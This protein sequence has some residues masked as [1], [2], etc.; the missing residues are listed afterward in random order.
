MY[1]KNRSRKISD[2]ELDSYFLDGFQSAEGPLMFFDTLTKQRN[3]CTG[4]I[5]LET[6]GD[7]FF[8]IQTW[9]QLSMQSFYERSQHWMRIISETGGSYQNLAKSLF[10]HFLP[11]EE[12]PEN[13]ELKISN[14]ESKLLQWKE[15]QEKA[16]QAYRIHPELEEQISQCPWY[17]LFC[18]PRLKSSEWQIV[19]PIT[20]LL[21]NFP[22]H[23]LEDLV[24]QM[25][26]GPDIDNFLQ[27]ENDLSE[28]MQN[29]DDLD[30]NELLDRLPSFDNDWVGSP[31]FVMPKLT[32]GDRP[33]FCDFI[34]NSWYSISLI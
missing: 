19:S 32:T 10:T 15:D 7:Y 13:I 16:I 33:S 2:K 27:A 17:N 23:P 5:T 25:A 34:D 30:I 28:Y 21:D 8:D 11:Q 4:R 22:D 24:Y 31:F 26:C 12:P 6:I 14:I 9:R 20:H 18:W 1:F 29:A 3:N